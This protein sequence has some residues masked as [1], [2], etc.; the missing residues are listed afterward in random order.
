MADAGKRRG[1]LSGEGEAV[2]MG[3][4]ARYWADRLGDGPAVTHDGVTW[5]WAEL[6]ARANARAR[7]LEERGVGFNDFVTIAL[8]NGN[9]FYETSLAVWKLGATPAPVSWR[10]PLAEIAAIVDL[11]G[12]K[13]VCGGPDALACAARL[14]EGFDA[15]GYSQEPVPARV[16]DAWKG[17][18]SGGSTGRPK[19][20][21]DHNPA[22]AYP[23]ADLM[24]MPQASA[25]LNPGP[26]YHNAPFVVTHQALF[27]GNHVVGMRKFDAAEAL[28]LMA[29]H[30]VTWIN[31]VPTMMHRIWRLPEAERLSHDLSALKTIW[32]MA[33][34]MPV[35][36]KEAWIEWLGPDRI[37][38]LYGGTEGVGHTV[39]SG[40]EWLEHKGSV[41]KALANCAIR[42]VGEDG[43]IL[44][45]REEGEIYFM[46]ETGPGSTYHYLGADEKRTPDGWE[47]IGDIGWLDEEGYLYLADRRTD[48]ILSGGANIY[49]AEVEAALMDHPGV[50]SAVAIGLPDDDLGQIVHAIVH[51]R[52]DQDA[53]DGDAL[54]AFLADRLVRYKIPRSF[55]FVDA[56]LRDD[57]GK[58]R[59]SKL[60]AERLAALRQAGG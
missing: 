34:P 40:S 46:P 30:K 31:M 22:L 3:D 27:R 37:W 42:I 39:I 58:V 41:G 33:A 59:R 51:P 55:E 54:A 21:V 38:E 32:H 43:R 13:V 10:L 36:L 15:S 28:A 20:I 44:G 50:D 49:P 56:P 29:R 14:P 47:T 48:L 5:S 25:I 53:L 16:G 1:I 35:W 17:V 6:D 24:H 26:L 4:A 11:V 18:T 23:D 7:A 2:P 57:A 45:P 12:P 52:E 19:V 9:E 8:P 60:R